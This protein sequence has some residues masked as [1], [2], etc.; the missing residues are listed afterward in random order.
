[1]KAA[2]WARF[3]R[4]LALF[5]VFACL[6][7]F[8]AADAVRGPHG[9]EASRQITARIGTMTKELG[10]LR[11]EHARLERDAALL[12]EKANSDPSLLDEEARALDL[13]HPSDIVIL[14]GE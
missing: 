11:A 8:V 2:G 13:A 14:H 1:M 12:K 10:E 9:L 5:L 3:S 4:Q 6:I 7:G